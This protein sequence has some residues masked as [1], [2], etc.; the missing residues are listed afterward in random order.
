MRKATWVFTMLA[1][2]MIFSVS[3]SFNSRS[4]RADGTY[5]IQNVDHTISVLSN[6]Y[7]LMNDTITL[8]GQAPPSFLLGFPY[9]FGSYVLRCVASEVNNTSNTFT[10]A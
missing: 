5:T 4:V 10:S 3:M 7:V 8:S 6:G 9:T 1:V 2:A